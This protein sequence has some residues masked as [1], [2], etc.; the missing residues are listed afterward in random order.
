M[1]TKSEKLI[2]EYAGNTASSTGLSYNVAL[3]IVTDSHPGLVHA[4]AREREAVEFEELNPSEKVL[5]LVG[6]YSI[7]GRAYAQTDLKALGAFIAK[8]R[9]EL[10]L[11]EQVLGFK[12]K[13]DGATILAI[14]RGDANAIRGVHLGL[15]AKE[16]EVNIRQLIELLPETMRVGPDFRILNSGFPFPIPKNEAGLTKEAILEVAR[17]DPEAYEAY[18]LNGRSTTMR[19]AGIELNNRAVEEMKSNPDLDYLGAIKIV[20]NA[21]PELY[22]RYDI[23]H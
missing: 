22:R 16:L 8:R 14:E 21:D 3:K 18:E 20:C 2:H 12:S 13:S 5:H 11:S 6:R 10:N 15:L 23:A 4:A 19:D 1:I 9:K 7:E 17:R